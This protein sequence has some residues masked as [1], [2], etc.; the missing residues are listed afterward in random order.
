M[1]GSLLKKAA[2]AIGMMV[3][4]RERKFVLTP[5][6]LLYFEP[7][8]KDPKGTMNLCEIRNVEAIAEKKIG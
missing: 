2:G 8:R 5:T 6:R 1:E 4:W 3:G 7:G